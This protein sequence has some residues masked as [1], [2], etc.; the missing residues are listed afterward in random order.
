MTHTI[1][2]KDLV[3]EQDISWSAVVDAWV[4]REGT[5]WDDHWKPEGYSSLWHW[6]KALL[7]KYGF[8]PFDLKSL[9]WKQCVVRNPVQTATQF[10]S[11]PYSGWV[12]YRNDGHRQSTPFAEHLQNNQ[13]MSVPDFE[14]RIATF[15]KQP[16]ETAIAIRDPKTMKTVLVDGHH[17]VGSF[18]KLG[19]TNRSTDVELELHIADIQLQDHELFEQWMQGNIPL[20]D[21]SPDSVEI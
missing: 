21:V 7:R 16:R 6:R 11:G 9:Q 2:D 1:T 20:V 17:T 18:A 14:N 5:I 10:H 13:F 15:G 19:A 3:F 8:E 4:K 12:K